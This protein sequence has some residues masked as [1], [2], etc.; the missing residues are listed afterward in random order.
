[1]PV[2]CGRNSQNINGSTTH[3]KNCTQPYS[4]KS[5]NLSHTSRLTTPS[6]ISGQS[7]ARPTRASMRSSIWL[8]KIAMNANVMGSRSQNRP[9]SFGCQW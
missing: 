1:V 2:Y 6:A 7:S 8:A 9:A 3:G 4:R 5:S